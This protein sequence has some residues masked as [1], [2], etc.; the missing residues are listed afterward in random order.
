M[1]SCEAHVIHSRQLSVL[2]DKPAHKLS[3]LLSSKSPCSELV[4]DHVAMMASR[5]SLSSLLTFRIC[6]FAPSRLVVDRACTL[7]RRH[8]INSRY[9]DLQTAR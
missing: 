3:A 6:D 2:N 1:K 9:V 4:F 5:Q 7:S 8:H